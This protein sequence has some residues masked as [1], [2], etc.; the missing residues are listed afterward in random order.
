MKNMKAVIVGEGLIFHNIKSNI[1]FPILSFRSLGH[2]D[3][4]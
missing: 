1:Y 2:A 3:T 4:R